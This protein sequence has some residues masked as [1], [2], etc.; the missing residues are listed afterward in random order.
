M[1]WFSNACS[2]VGSFVSS[3]VSA[4]SSAISSIGSAIVRGATKLIEIAGVSLEGVIETIKKVGV[5]LGIIEPEENIEELG[6]KAMEAEKKPEDFEYVSDYIKYL[7]EEVQLD[8]EKFDK[9]EKKDKWARKA[10]GATIVSKGIEE[11]KG[12]NI[13]EEF[14]VEASRNKMKSEEIEKMIDIFKEEKIDNN[15]AEYCKGNLKYKDE[16]KTGNMLVKMYQELEPNLGIEE[17]EDKIMGMEAI[18]QKGGDF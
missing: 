2:A 10:V 1:G 14:W 7:K 5:A 18:S 16:V 12:T 6:A 17:I 4:V 9:A 3:C 15:F 13:P 11:K 8:K